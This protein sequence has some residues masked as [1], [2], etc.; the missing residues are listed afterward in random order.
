MI[1]RD[2]TR[3]E[4]VSHEAHPPGRHVR[5]RAP[6]GQ[7]PAI[8]NDEPTNGAELSDGDTIKLERTKV[9]GTFVNGTVVRSAP[10]Q[11]GDKIR[12]ADI[13]LVYER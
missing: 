2:W 5:H 8:L 7:E 12:L 4:S 6:V 3:P 9:K 1:L 10:L 11:P 13:N